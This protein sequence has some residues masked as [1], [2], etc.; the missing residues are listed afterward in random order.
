MGAGEG[1]RLGFLRGPQRRGVGWAFCPMATAPGS[2]VIPLALIVPVASNQGGLGALLILGGMLA[3]GIAM[4]V[5]ALVSAVAVAWNLYTPRLGGVGLAGQ[6]LVVIGNLVVAGMGVA[7][8]ISL[9][10][11][12]GVE[13]LI[14]ALCTGFGCVVA[15]IVV[16]ATAVSARRREP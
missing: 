1:G 13:L 16:A 6:G 8:A 15:A 7:L 10:G 11:A 9:I 12:P 14:G 2:A 5:A 4:P 3:Y